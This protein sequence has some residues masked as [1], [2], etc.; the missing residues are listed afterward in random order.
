MNYS[1]CK[2]IYI[3]GKRLDELQ[4]VL[5]NCEEL[6][7][8]SISYFAK[9]RECLRE[10]RKTPCDLLV[11]AIGG[12]PN[13]AGNLLT[14]VANTVPSMVILCVEEAPLSA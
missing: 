9:H 6:D 4:A 3:S 7:R 12:C 14:Q 11:I 13:E 8:A 10:L 5:E 2:R 1:F